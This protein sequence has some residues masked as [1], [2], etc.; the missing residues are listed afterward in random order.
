[1]WR[2]SSL[3]CPQFQLLWSK[4]QFFGFSQVDNFLWKIWLLSK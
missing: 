3:L 2:Q 4:M 1:L